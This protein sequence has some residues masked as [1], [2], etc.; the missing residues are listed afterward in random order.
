M[1]SK[2]LGIV[3]GIPCGCCVVSWTRGFVDGPG[4]LGKLNH[5]TFQSWFAFM[6]DLE[7][8]DDLEFGEFGDWIRLNSVTDIRQASVELPKTPVFVEL[9]KTSVLRR[10]LNR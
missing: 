9:P 6:D 4:T 7:F 3:L 10:F 1:L 5:A 2:R 8:D